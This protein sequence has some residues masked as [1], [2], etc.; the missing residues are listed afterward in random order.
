MA[1][2]SSNVNNYNSCSV[3]DLDYDDDE[4]TAPYPTCSDFIIGSVPPGFAV[5]DDIE[6]V[7][8]DT[9]V[10]DPSWDTVAP[11]RVTK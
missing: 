9:P 11:Y 8:E 6:V 4:I 7:H 5:C 3:A 2:H 1:T 10:D